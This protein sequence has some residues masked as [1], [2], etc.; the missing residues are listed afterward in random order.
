MI[1]F[2]GITLDDPR[3]TAMEILES[4]LSGMSSRV[5]HSIREERGLAYY[6][7]AR[8]RL[9]VD[10]GQFFLVAGTRPDAAAE[11]ESLLLTEVAR[12]AREGI[13][14]DEIARAKSQLIADHD[15][16]LQNNMSLSLTSA[17]NELYG[18]GYAYDFNAA[19]RIES[20]TADQIREA[21]ASIL[22]TNRMA[23]SIVL[24][25]ERK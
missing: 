10:P 8:Q 20:V 7:G 2:P 6:A 19:Q 18:M 11:V 24:P 13:Q 15:M 12:V 16:Q 14:P 23:V 22:V 4:S 21:A 3:R 25:V 9:G 1:G 5:F 17:L